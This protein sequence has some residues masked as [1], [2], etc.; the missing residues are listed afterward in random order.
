MSLTSFQEVDILKTTSS[1]IASKK[2]CESDWMLWN[3]TGSPKSL[4]FCAQ[5][6]PCL[7]AANTDKFRQKKLHLIYVTKLCVQERPLSL[8]IE[9]YKLSDEN[10][11][12][13]HPRACI[14]TFV[15][16]SPK[17]FLSSSMANRCDWLL[18][19]WHEVTCF[20]VFPFQG[21]FLSLT[22]PLYDSNRMLSKM[23]ALNLVQFSR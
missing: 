20:F 17:Q 23:N 19:Q 16:K 8:P 6:V 1:K 2:P 4:H 14:Y 9:F 21:Q 18:M 22:V 3:V 5:G 15:S 7:P 11:P 12:V 10:D 13:L